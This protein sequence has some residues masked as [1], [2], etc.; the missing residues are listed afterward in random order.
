MNSGRSTANTSRT[1]EGRASPNRD[2]SSSRG[3]KSEPVD[4]ISVRQFEPKFLGENRYRFKNGDIWEFTGELH[5]KSQILN[6]QGKYTISST[7][8]VYSGIFA[9]GKIVG[10]G[11]AWYADGNRLF[12][13]WSE[14]GCEGTLMYASGDS[15]SGGLAESVRSGF[16]VCE[17]LNGM[18]L[19]SKQTAPQFSPTTMN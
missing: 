19:L 6:T 17:F 15:Y 9:Q 16:G 2:L 11:E 7:G 5:N 4:K 18:N 13:F 10:C 14:K 12:G 3:Q 1:F 8:T